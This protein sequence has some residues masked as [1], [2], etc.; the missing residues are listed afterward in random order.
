MKTTGMKNKILSLAAI[1][2]T[3]F[4]LPT[5]AHAHTGHGATHGFFNGAGHPI[6]GLDHLL[7]MIAV[8]LWAAMM[9]GRAVW[10]VPSAFV[11]VMAIGGVLGMSGV[12]LPF[13][14]QGILLSVVVLGVLIAA[15][16]KKMPLLVGALLAGT[17]ALFHGHAHGTEMPSDTSG[18]AYGVGFAVSTV[19]LHAAGIGLG[20]ALK[21]FASETCVRVAGAAVVVAG[22]GLWVS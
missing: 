19:L 21:K 10:V 14:E 22:I 12:G 6:G 4:L 17:F 11:G 5:L 16:V 15:A 13:V 8:G 7:A 3:F 1:T 20:M 9:G 18:L 2:A